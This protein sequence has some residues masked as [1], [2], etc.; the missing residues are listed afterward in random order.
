MP[1]RENRK[2]YTL[3]HWLFYGAIIVFAGTAIGMAHSIL[4]FSN[5]VTFAAGAVA[6]TII[7]T[8][9]L[10]EDIFGP[11]HTPREQRDRSA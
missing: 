5:G 7:C 10:W 9:A 4:G 3:R 2:I 6:G 1:N 8:M 11:P